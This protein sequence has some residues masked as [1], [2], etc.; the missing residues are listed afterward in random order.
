METKTALYDTAPQGTHTAGAVALP[1]PVTAFDVWRV[2]RRRWGVFLLT[3]AVVSAT[4][5]YLTSKLPR[6]YMTQARVLVDMPTDTAVPTN[7]LDLLRGGS[8]RP[9][10]VEI[11]KIKSRS[12]L[13]KLASQVKQPGMDATALKWAMSATGSADGAILDIAAKT[14]DPALSQK[15]A[16]TA[17]ALYMKQVGV[18]YNDKADQSQSRLRA[19]RDKAL[20]EKEQ[21]E[22]TLDK[23]NAQ[24]GTTDPSIYFRQRAAQTFDVKRNLE[25]AKRGLPLQQKQ[26][27]TYQEQ[28]DSI[29]NYLQGGFTAVKN[30]AINRYQD[31]I[32]QLEVKRK[33]LLQLYT[34]DSTDVQEVEEDIKI[35]QEAI[36]KAGESLP[37]FSD[38][39]NFGRNSDY[40]LL[41]SKILEAQRN[42]RATNQAIASESQRLAELQAEQIKLAPKQSEYERLKRKRDSANEAYQK[43]VDG[44]INMEQTKVVSAPQLRLLE[45]ADLPT[46]P[47]SPKPLLN[48]VMAA[49]LGLMFGCGMAVVAEYLSGG[50][51]FAP[52]REIDP[53]AYLPRVGGVPLLGTMSV[54]LPAPLDAGLPVP[55]DLHSRAEDILREVGFMLAARHGREPVPVVLFAGTRSDDTSAAVASHLAAMLVRDGMRVTLVDADRTQPR[56]NEVFGKPNTPGLADVLAGRA[57]ARDIL[58][59]GKG[60]E[61][62]FLAAGSPENAAPMTEA[63]LRKVFEELASPR[64]T[65]IVIVSGPSV[66]QAPLISPLE[67]AANKGMVLVAAPGRPGVSGPAESV[68]RA[69]RLLSNG[70]KP[71][72]LGVVVGGEESDEN[73]PRPVLTSAH[74]ETK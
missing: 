58:H 70:Y 73:A 21:A 51:A 11:E 55:L 60:G 25:D 31:E 2:L 5:W 7:A 45:S 15:I 67:R 14:G 35:R 17:T 59:I 42:I 44:L 69:R 74:E 36:K 3:L 13:E 37:Y 41:T 71:R 66:W 68:A 10:T 50:E 27:V 4:S 62:R 57:R 9:I 34:A 12:F 33:E 20:A 63:G 43:A 40:S 30:P 46:A 53:G 26:L 28:R 48:A 65:D 64:D 54:A 32:Q 52:E 23:F 56:L 18:E 6:V 47:V 49:A 24:M 72:I 22:A 16:N 61:L 39:K 1:P 8:S 19:A 38:S 29:P